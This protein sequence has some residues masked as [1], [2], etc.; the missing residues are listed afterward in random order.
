M[1]KTSR[2]TWRCMERRR[3]IAT[4][5][6]EHDATVLLTWNWHDMTSNVTTN[7][8]SRQERAA[9]HT[10]RKWSQTWVA[11]VVT[12]RWHLVRPGIELIALS[13]AAAEK[14]EVTSQSSRLADGILFQYADAVTGN[15][16]SSMERC[17][18]TRVEADC[19]YNNLD[20]QSVCYTTLF[21]G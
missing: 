19:H 4:F 13:S 15:S 5:S 20:S 12:I 7:I 16:Q 21:S 10:S 2:P 3:R 11:F 1:S 17:I 9:R 18:W 8:I 14:P 6:M